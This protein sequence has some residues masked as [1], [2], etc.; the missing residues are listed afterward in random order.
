MM[1]GIAL[2]P[3]VPVNVKDFQTEA[4]VNEL[5]SFQGDVA[6]REPTIREKPAAAAFLAQ[7]YNG[8]ENVFS[9]F[10]SSLSDYM[11]KIKD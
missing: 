2:C 9:H 7:F 1:I 10:K 6:G 4:T 5:I 11:E 8:V 3:I